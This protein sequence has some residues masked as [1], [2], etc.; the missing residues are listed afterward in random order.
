MKR[1]GALLFAMTM[2][3]AACGGRSTPS[4]E[5]ATTNEADQEDSSVTQESSGKNPA[6]SGK[7]AGA[8][9]QGASGT[10]SS[11]DKATNSTKAETSPS[12]SDNSAS[13]SRS[14]PRPAAPLPQGTYT[15]DTDGRAT[16]SG[17]SR[18][19]PKET[20]L[21]AGDP[22][23]EVQVLVRDLRDG[24]GNGTV[25]E[26]H[27]GFAKDG[28]YLSYVKTTSTFPGGF[29]DVREFKLD[30]PEQIAPTGAGPGFSR[31]FVMEGSGTRAEVTI[32]GVRYEN[33]TIA[34]DTVRTLV[35]DTRII[36]SGALEGEQNSTSW[37]W[38]KHV[39]PVKEHVESDV[40]NGAIRVQTKYDAILQTLEPS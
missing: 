6:G 10:K 29:T 4:D 5:A 27:I 37:F 38:T 17:G 30:P 35:V 15:Y 18:D 14:G 8:V 7:K 33:V 28:V 26:T 39:V 34:G 20:T 32:K 36:F 24:D 23:N 19:L 40:R 9:K 16:V 31:S 13:T 2:L 1:I 25:V 11:G 12:S 22:D 3:V 21:S